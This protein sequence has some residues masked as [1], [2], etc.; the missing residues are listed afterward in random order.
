MT[1]R[2]QPHFGQIAIISRNAE[3]M[4]KNRLSESLRAAASSKLA[5]GVLVLL[6]GILAALIA[7]LLEALDSPP[8]FYF[9]SLILSLAFLLHGSRLVIRYARDL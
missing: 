7:F 3:D 6:I 8:P 1:S 2:Y 9:I 4:V 5:L